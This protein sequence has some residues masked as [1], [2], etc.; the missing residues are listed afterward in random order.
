MI[1][2]GRS[3]LFVLERC[4]SVRRGSTVFFFAV[5]HTLTT[6]QPIDLRVAIDG[7]SVRI[8]HLK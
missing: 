5:E 6:N 4:P 2:F 7:V 3:K 1:S 8:D